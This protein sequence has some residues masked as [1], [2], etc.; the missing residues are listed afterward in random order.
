MSSWCVASLADGD[1]HLAEPEPSGHLVT[2]QCNG[3]QFHPLVVLRAAP[4]DE[5]QVCPACRSGRHQD[6]SQPHGRV[7]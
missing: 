3:R 2:A 1:T 5:A 4:P 7:R 6:T